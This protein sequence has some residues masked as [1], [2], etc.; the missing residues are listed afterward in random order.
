MNQFINDDAI[1]A[2]T[3]AMEK[4]Y[5]QFVAMTK[6]QVEKVFPA[7][8]K[9]FD[10]MAALNKA[11]Y[12]AATK[13]GQAAAKAF[14]TLGKSVATYNQEAFQDSVESAQALFACKTFQ[15]VVELQAKQAQA[16]FDKALAQTAKVSELTT[17]A[18]T[19]A[20]EPMNAQ[21]TK[22]FKAFTK[23]AKAASTAS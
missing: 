2:G 12:E 17:K 23:Q 1:K 19:E 11:S 21:G 13:A 14:E 4:G 3:A 9:N 16:G 8:A 15:D 20:M 5:E 7:A 10:D 18:A 22:A 6:A